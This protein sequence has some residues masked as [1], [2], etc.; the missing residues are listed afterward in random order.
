M[1]SFWQLAL[2]VAAFSLACGRSDLDGPEYVKGGAGT[3]GAGANGGAPAVCEG[4]CLC[5]PT[6]ACPPGCYSPPGGGCYNGGPPASTGDASADETGPSV[7]EAIEA[8]G[9]AADLSDAPVNGGRVPYRALAVTTGGYHTCVILDD[10]GVKCWG[11]NDFGQLGLGDT[12]RRGSLPSEMGDALPKV[13]LG[14]GR[15]ATAIAAGESHTCAILDDGSV[16]CWGIG[17]RLGLP[18]IP[19]N[20]NRGDEPGEMGD[21]LPA[22]DFGTGRRARLLVG[23]VDA[24]CAALDDGTVSCWG[25]ITDD[26]LPHVMPLASPTSVTAMSPGSFGVIVLFADGSVQNIP[27]LDPV[28]PAIPPG[29]QATAV[30]GSQTALCAVLSQGTLVCSVAI[31]LQGVFAA[32]PPPGPRLV[33][34]GAFATVGL[35]GLLN[36]GSVRCEAAFGTDCTPD[37]CDDS[38]S[39]GTVGIRLGADATAIG[40]GGLFH[41][42][43][44]L[45]D[46][47]VRCWGGESV[48]QAGGVSYA[49]LGSSF[50]PIVQ[51][52][53][54]VGF[55]P[56]HDV[57]LGTHE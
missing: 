50:D 30:G 45:V 27:T 12:V 31:A 55:G 14:T 15:T 35:C 42:C 56:F 39:D 1:R 47:N 44:L 43:A 40:T 16:K 2:V 36:E 28:A 10:D 7:D 20:A 46:G 8:P 21:A 51:N 41:T 37:W 26:G 34:V 38:A 49:P 33:A 52:G 13:D 54:I 18:A 9:D 24:S 48:P 22:L 53:L 3:G 57:D 32:T 11:F 17:A 19:G 5:F 6:Q 29:Q 23:S 25:A 4:G